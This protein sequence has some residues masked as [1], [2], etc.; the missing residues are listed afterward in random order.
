M[1]KSN[2][3]PDFLII[4][5]GKSGTTSIDNYLKQHPEI[6]MSSVKEPNFFAYELTDIDE[7]KEFPEELKHF[8]SSVTSLNEYQALFD[9]ATPQQLK[10]ETSNTY[11]Y[12]KD[13]PSRISHHLPH[14]KL[15][16]ILRHPADRLYSRYLHLA[17][18]N[19]LPSAKFS[20]CFNKETIWWKRNDL[21][22]EGFYYKHLSR[23]YEKYTKENIKVFLY[24][25]IKLDLQKLLKEIFTFLNVD[26]SFVC[27]LSV[28]YNESGM[29]KNKFINNIVGG[30]GKLQT[31]FKS[32]SPSLYN[33]A[34]NNMLA[35]KFINQLR[36]KNLE[37]PKIDPKIE[38]FLTHEVYKD[39][40]LK[41]QTLINRDLSSWLNK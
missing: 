38:Q 5:A 39:D 14:A 40:I 35:Q 12:G 34:K 19:R 13:A 22:N 3:M 27:D 36:S 31:F 37:K 24:E 21:I 2:N 26:N 20:D 17:R 33:T 32:I 41:L 29:I 16:A 9:E 1:R 10:G 23:Y 6:F 7:L 4:G 8:K 30:N 15:I 25:D 28:R 11:L 18:D